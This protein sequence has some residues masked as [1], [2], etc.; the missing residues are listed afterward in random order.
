MSRLSTKYLIY[1]FLYIIIIIL[2]S[3]SRHSS[4][5]Q[6]ISRADELIE[7]RPDSSL[8]ILSNVKYDELVNDD[9]RAKYAL[10]MSMAL[11]KNYIDTTTFDVLQPAIDY[12]ADHGTANDKLRTFYYQGRIYQNAGQNNDAMKAFVSALD[13]KSQATDT[14]TIA[15]ALIAQAIIFNNAYNF[16][17]A[18]L[19]NL[20]AANLHGRIGRHELRADALLRALNAALLNEGLCSNNLNAD[21]IMQIC[22]AEKDY[23]PFEIYTAYRLSYLQKHGSREELLTQLSQLEQ[24]SPLTLDSKLML[25][26]TYQ[27]IDEPQKAL[28]VLDKIDASS[29]DIDSARYISIKI[30]AYDK[31]G[32]SKNCLDNYKTFYT[33]ISKEILDMFEN[34][35]HFSEEKHKLELQAQKEAKKKDDILFASISGGCILGLI[36]VVLLLFIRK[37]KIAK[38]LAIQKEI[39]AKLENE[40]LLHKI[41]LIENERDE[42][43]IIME[44]NAEL[45]DEVNN[46]VKTRIEM[47]NSI[48]AYHIV[49]EQQPESTYATAVKEMLGDTSAFMNTTRLAFK[50]SHPRFIQ[51]FVDQG[52]T[53]D[54][55]NYVCLYAIGL[56]GKD[57]GAYMKKRSHV[58]ISSAIR[59]K[60]GIDKHETNIGIYVRRLLKEL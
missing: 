40:N 28:D 55:I 35:L 9:E 54:E 3:C 57:V 18:V 39:A 19:A 25:A 43:A 38:R 21:S 59:K 36:I 12:Y 1:I 27:K 34:K 24:I 33:L 60:L 14:L 30:Q 31:L 42:L 48:L 46:A 47:L 11:D 32:D 58:N 44:K 16:T 6:E 51:Y 37:N 49:A 23:I 20:E 53:D 56:R 41:G 22:E 50:A 26:N 29:L 7:T 13:L 15:R 10:I 17:D 2:S 8:T 4:A 52:L 5:W 45:P